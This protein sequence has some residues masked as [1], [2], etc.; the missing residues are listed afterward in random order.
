M[1]RAVQFKKNPYPAHY[2]VQ[3]EDLFVSNPTKFN[4]SNPTEIYNKIFNIKNKKKL[5]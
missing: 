5:F 2:N 3:R 1:V 4:Q